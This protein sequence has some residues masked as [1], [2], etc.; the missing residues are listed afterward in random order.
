VQGDLEGDA[1]GGNQQQQRVGFNERVGFLGKGDQKW[2]TRG[3]GECIL[4]IRSLRYWG[5]WGDN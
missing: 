2:K 4:E 1:A 3:V 5:E